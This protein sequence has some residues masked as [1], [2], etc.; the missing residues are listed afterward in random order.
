[1]GISYTLQLLS[2]S[3]LPASVLY[4]MV[5]GGSVVLSAVAGRIFFGE[6]PD[7]ITLAGLALSFVAT[8][9][10]LF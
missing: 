6:K 9:L 3:N 2:A 7:R 5:T 10:F 1:N 4:P 8:F